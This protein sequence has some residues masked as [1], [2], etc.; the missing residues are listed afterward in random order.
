M[1][2]VVMVRGEAD[3]G[4]DLEVYSDLRDGKA[5]GPAVALA[6]CRT[7]YPCSEG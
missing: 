1:D 3:W 6:V 4:K 2:A 5:A 7:S